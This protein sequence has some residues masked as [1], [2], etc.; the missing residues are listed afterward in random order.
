MHVSWH[1][2]AR[3]ERGKQRPSSL[4]V[5]NLRRVLMVPEVARRLTDELRNFADS[6]DGT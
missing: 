5:T 2:V 6:G 1:T 3:W 4:A